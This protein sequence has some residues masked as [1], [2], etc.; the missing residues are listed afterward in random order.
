MVQRGGKYFTAKTE[1]VLEPIS[2]SSSSSFSSS[3]ATNSL[4]LQSILL[5]LTCPLDNT[6]KII[7]RHLGPGVLLIL[8]PY[9]ACPH[10]PELPVLLVHTH[11]LPA[12]FVHTHTHTHR[13]SSSPL[14]Q[15][16]SVLPLGILLTLRVTWHPVPWLVFHGFAENTYVGEGS[17]EEVG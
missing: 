12:L 8:F 7:R 5:Q 16:W 14:W 6:Q 10:T 1:T 9:K 2:S 3:L 11:T 4:H 17:R 15:A 13:S